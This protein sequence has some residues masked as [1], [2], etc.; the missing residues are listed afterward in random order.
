MSETEARDSG[1]VLPSVNRWRI[2]SG[3]TSASPAPEATEAVSKSASPESGGSQAAPKASQQPMGSSTGPQESVLIVEDDPQ[4][5]RAITT[6]LRRRGYAVSETGTVAGALRDLNDH[7][8]DWILLD[9][10]L[11]D[12]SG[13]DVIRQ[14]RSRKL[15]SRVC[16]I[17]GCDADMINDARTQGAEHAFTKPLDVE[18]LMRVMSA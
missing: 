14:V 18:R 4:A 15:S 2:K 5:R 12:G 17:T 10:M 16:I 6:I 3:P 13:T 9:L 1:W 11:P 7:R 8:R